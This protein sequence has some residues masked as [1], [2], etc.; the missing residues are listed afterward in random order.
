MSEHDQAWEIENR[1]WTG[2]IQA[3]EDHMAKDCVMVFPAPVGILDY[4]AVIEALKDAPRW[5]DVQ[6][7]RKLASACGNDILTLAYLGRGLKGT[8]QYEAFCSSTYHRFS[9]GWKIIQ[10]QQT[11]IG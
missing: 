11:P 3:Y 7:N 6:F 5:D 10:H 9:E 1:L 4:Y 2:G 8:E